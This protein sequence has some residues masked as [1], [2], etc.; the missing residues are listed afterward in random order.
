MTREELQ[1][2]MAVLLGGRAAE[3]VAF[4]QLSTGAADDLTKA[5]DIARS[6]VTHYGMYEPLG[7]VVY[8]ADPPSFL[9]TPT[10]M[11]QRREFSEETAREID[12]AVR[13]IIQEAFEKAIDVIQKHPEHLEQGAQ[14]LLQ[15]ETLNEEDLAA[16]KEASQ[17]ST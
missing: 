15:K 12:H 9:Q 8:E 11:P 3:Q 13:E 5:T 16:L 14:L 10:I 17:K 2:K 1:N 6:M 7:Q 4:G